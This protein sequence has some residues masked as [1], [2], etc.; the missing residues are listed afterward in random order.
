MKKT[1]EE[2]YCR[3]ITEENPIF[4]FITC[5]FLGGKNRSNP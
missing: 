3:K 4:I 5:F 2:W 1:L